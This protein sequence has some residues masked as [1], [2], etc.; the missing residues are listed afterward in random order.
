MEVHPY[1]AL[2]RISALAF[3]GLTDEL[4]Q[5]MI[6]M[7]SQD[8]RAGMLPPDTRPQDWIGLDLIP[9]RKVDRVLGHPVRWIRVKPERYFG[10]AD[11]QPLGYTVRVTT[12]E[13]TLLDGLLDPESSGGL[14]NVLR[15]WT[16][17][18]DT[19]DVD[20]LVHQA[21]RFRVAVLR[22]RVGFILESLD[23]QHPLLDRWQATATR[24][25]SSKLLASAPYADTY[26]DR[27]NLSLNASIAALRPDAP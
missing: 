9:G 24:G 19:L 27:W 25:G 6:A 8:E 1:A 10:V 15:A 14:E 7:V 22:Q 13:R 21:E 16:L 20:T 2:S 3:H 18:R 4:P 17:A 26:S 11:Y 12:P 5:T 23:L